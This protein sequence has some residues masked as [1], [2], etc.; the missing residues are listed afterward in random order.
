MCRWSSGPLPAGGGT[1][2]RARLHEERPAGVLGR[3]AGTDSLQELRRVLRDV[4]QL[5]EIGEVLHG[6]E[7]ATARRTLLNAPLDAATQRA[8]REGLL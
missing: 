2:I 8:K 6:P 3:L 1:E 4:K 5:L 7:P